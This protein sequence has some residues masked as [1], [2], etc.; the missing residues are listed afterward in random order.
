[1]IGFASRHSILPAQRAVSRRQQFSSEV[2]CGA[3]ELAVPE[4]I[5]LF[6][7]RANDQFKTQISRACGRQ[8]NLND[9]IVVTRDHSVYRSKNSMT[10][11]GSVW[12][13][14][15]D[16]EQAWRRSRA[17]LGQDAD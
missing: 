14:T 15:I 16:I 8:S 3:I 11:A 4:G 2:R 17:Y 12:I 13:D 7:S 5:D 10:D 9:S 6:I 1:M